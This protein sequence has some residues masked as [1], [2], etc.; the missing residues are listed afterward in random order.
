MAPSRG[1]CRFCGEPVTVQQKAAWP[2][3]GWEVERE[4][5]GA[6]KILGRER[7]LSTIAHEQCAEKAVKVGEHQTSIFEVLADA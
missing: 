2:V 3:R 4:Q 1:S 5:G 7:D 6:N